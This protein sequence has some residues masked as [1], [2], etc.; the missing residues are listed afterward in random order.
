MNHELRWIDRR[1]REMIHQASW[2]LKRKG[3]D[4]ACRRRIPLYSSAEYNARSHE[5]ESLRVEEKKI[6]YRY[7]D[8]RAVH[9]LPEPAYGAN[10]KTTSMPLSTTVASPWLMDL[11][12][13]SYCT[14]EIFLKF[15]FSFWIQCFN[16]L[17]IIKQ[18]LSFVP[19]CSSTEYFSHKRN[20]LQFFSKLINLQKLLKLQ[21]VS[22]NLNEEKK[23]M[24]LQRKVV[25][26]VGQESRENSR[27]RDQTSLGMNRFSPRMG[28]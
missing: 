15:P 17:G 13:R 1:D 5:R 20:F 28:R 18:N 16:Q 3:R 10:A 4:V 24:E 6:G 14:M 11:S 12:N 26:R 8:S 23:I 22:F 19:L 2:I 9:S 27:S 25:S 7:F 21:E